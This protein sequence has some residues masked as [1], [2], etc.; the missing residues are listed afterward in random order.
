MQSHELLRE[1]FKETSP[2]QVADDL[3][4]SL[5]MIYKWAQPSEE[6]GSGA[7]NPLDRIEQ[8]LQCTKDER[9]A[10]WVA[11][12]AGGFYIENPEA[13]W[14]H[15]FFLIPA[16][17]EV[18]QEF[19][20]LLSVV[21][22]AA[23]DNHISRKESETIRGRWEKLKSLTEGFVQCCEQGNF[24]KLGEALAHEVGKPK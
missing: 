7:L 21:A 4:L 19:A 9:I 8:L 16:T 11:E 18:V 1:V 23:S 10:Q 24:R 6:G 3:S 15:P 22:M 13:H 5:S 2:K 20:D 12:R 17:N 14:P